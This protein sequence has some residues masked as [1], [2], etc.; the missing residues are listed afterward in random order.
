MYTGVYFFSCAIDR[1]RF[2]HQLHLPGCAFKI[3]EYESPYKLNEFV[4]QLEELDDY[5]QEKVFYLLDNIGYDREEALEKHVDV[6]FYEGMT[7]EEVAENFVD[8][9]VYGEIPDNIKN[10]IDYK[11]IARDLDM[12]GFCQTEKGTF[13][14]Q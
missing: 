10:Y 5:S 2:D 8:E 9:G 7:L 12:E 3:E 6:L 13:F 11:A 1:R 4:E 14:Y